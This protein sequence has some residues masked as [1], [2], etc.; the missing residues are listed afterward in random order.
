MKY[1]AATATCGTMTVELEGVLDERTAAKTVARV[2]ELSCDD[3]VVDLSRARQV[4]E[5]ALAFLA[6]ALALAP[7]SHVVL[8]GLGSRQVRLLQVLGAGSLVE[9][10]R[11]ASAVARERAL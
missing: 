7:R 6:G 4:S 10:E 8:R 1:P 9:H 2:V 11:S 3:V 5:I